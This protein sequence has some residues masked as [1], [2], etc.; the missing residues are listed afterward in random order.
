MFP[1]LVL[2][3]QTADRITISR[4][5]FLAPERQGI[6][7]HPLCHEPLS[8]VL[9]CLWWPHVG[10]VEL[11]G[12]SNILDLK[13]WRVLFCGVA[14]KSFSTSPVTSLHGMESRHGKDCQ[15]IDLHSHHC[16]LHVSSI[17][18]WFQPHIKGQ[19]TVNGSAQKASHHQGK[20]FIYSGVLTKTYQNPN[21]NLT[22]RAKIQHANSKPASV[23]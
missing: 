19:A 8:F 2:L 4:N 21:L 7:A 13:N 9:V 6:K 11:L 5:T 23:V 15:K 18:D 12:A 20:P 3:S 16:F 10:S 17:S 14:K 1:R 22:H